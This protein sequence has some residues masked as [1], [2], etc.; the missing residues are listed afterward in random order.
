MG[1]TKSAKPQSPS[2]PETAHRRRLQAG[3]ATLTL[4][5]GAYVV[6]EELH[7]LLSPSVH[8]HG[9]AELL[10]HLGEACEK[11]AARLPGRVGDGQGWEGAAARA[12]GGPRLFGRAGPLL[13]GQVSATRPPRSVVTT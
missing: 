3:P 10:R 2:H 9:C 1:T 13:N 11:R 7:Q 4:H 8:V 12:S 5:Y 6:V